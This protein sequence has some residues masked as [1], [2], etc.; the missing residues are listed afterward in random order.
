M[1]NTR[2]PYSPISERAPLKW[3]NRA[4]VALC[5]VPNIECFH[6]DKPITRGEPHVPDIQG[7]S[8]RLWAS[9]GISNDECAGQVRHTRERG[10]EHGRENYPAI[11]RRATNAT[12]SGWDM[13]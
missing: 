3:P 13:A 7:Y 5:V 10:A 8:A 9:R 11:V 6:I 12:G 1:R 4:R 2:Y